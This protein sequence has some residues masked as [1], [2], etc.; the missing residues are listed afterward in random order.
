MTSVCRRLLPFVVLAVFWPAVLSAD[1]RSGEWA[2]QRSSLKP[3]PRVVWGGLENGLRYAILPHDGVPGRV[4]VQ[5]LVLAGSL[6]ERE[7]ERGLAHFVEHMA[8][9]GTRNFKSGEMISFFQSLGMEF[10]SDV[11]AMTTH[12]HTVYILDFNDNT[13]PLLRR[14]M[15]LLRDFADGIE[16]EQEEIDKERGVIMSELRIYDGF[17]FRSQNASTRFFFSGLTLPER[18]PIGL[19]EVINTAN[20]VDFREFYTRTYRPDLMI[21]VVSGDVGADQMIGLT[22]EFFGTMKKPATRIPDRDLGRLTGSKGVKADVFEVSHVGSASIQVASVEPDRDATD[23]VAARKRWHD[24]DLAAQLLTNRLRRMVTQSGGA[25]AS[26]GKIGGHVAATAG[27]FTSGGEGWRHALLS[28][29]QVIRL[30]HEK[31]FQAKEAEWMRKRSLLDLGKARAQYARLDP[32][33]IASAIVESIV[34]H[35]VFI[36]LE[37]DLEMRESFLRELNIA[38]INKAFRDSWI[39]DNLA[40]HL[41][42]EVVVKG[43]PTQIVDD[44]R[45]HR[46][47]GIS[48]VSMQPELTREFRLPEWGPPGEVVERRTVPEFGASLMKFGNGVR[49]NFVESSQE[50]SIVR[51][52]VRV[53]GGLFDLKGNRKAIRDFALET[54]LLSGTTHYMA[55]DI[56]SFVTSSMLE[57]SFDLEDH[58]A[59]TFRGAFGSEDLDT[60]LGIVAEFLFQPKFSRGAFNSELVGAMKNRQ[61]SSLGLQDGFRKLDNHLYRTDAR[62]VWG[63][64]IDY[65]TLGVSDVRNWVEGPLKQGYVEVTIV[66]DVPEELAVESMARTLGSLPERA[67]KKKTGSVRPVLMAARPGFQRVEFVGEDHQAVAIGVWPIDERISVQDRANLNILSRILQV[68]ISREIREDLGLAYSPSTEFQ[69]FP[70]YNSFSLIEATVDCSPQDAEDIARK[71]ERIA[72]EIATEGVTQDEFDGAIEPF[73]GHMRQAL[74]NNA[75]L[76]DNVLMRA[77]EDPSSVDEA[78]RI[79]EGMRTMVSLDA[80]NR[81]ATEILQSGNTRTV[82]IVPKPFVGV[83]QIDSGGSAGEAVIGRP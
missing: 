19:T 45:R 76:I 51:A 18:N 14:G 47:G 41:S 21:L 6:D 23:S 82:A 9:N 33:T 59:F 38:D 53:G 12:D 26:V 15:G 64:P 10:G 8:F 31:G 52:V 27:L 67:A 35:E 29:D 17:E 28:L 61:G 11:N 3:D 42:G 1:P 71:I 7:N 83:F 5:L 81:F 20:R 80:V 39:M 2:H 68:R 72:A 70:E 32:N 46:R 65:A 36:G 50:P 22:R 73:V 44:I 75:F 78:I 24:R 55:E 25:G 16:F 30:T 48:Y 62:F 49:F 60:F 77:Q 4:S 40:Y 79:K 37:A 66:G 69:A 57:F 34:A 63:E 43:G 74:A 56:G 13:E 54:V 58:D